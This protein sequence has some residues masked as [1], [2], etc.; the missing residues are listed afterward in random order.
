MKYQVTH[1]SR[2]QYAANVSHCYNLAHVLPRSTAQQRCLNSQVHVQPEPAMMAIRKDYFGNEVCYFS[3][4]FEHLELEVKAVSQVEVQTIDNLNFATGV[5]CQTVLSQLNAKE[6]LDAVQAVEY[7]VD[8]PLVRSAE[9]L[10]AYAEPSFA[11]NPPFL[12]A[13]MDLTQR[14]FKD[15]RYDPEST[16]VATPI[17]EVMEHRHGVCQDFA[18]VAIGCLRSLGYAARYVSGYI[19]TLPPPGQQKLVGADAS[20]AWFS[21]YVPGQGWYDF[22]PTNNKPGSDQ[23][24]IAAWGRDFSDVSPLKGVVFGGGDKQLL[25]ISVDVSRMD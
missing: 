24:I 20:H 2:Y 18:H 12:A 4:Q 9:N 11:D 7:R 10:K 19:E 6:T 16:T 17:D 1:I 25:E 5:D 21:V 13:V 14:I 3:V 22:D 23:H 15:F 8:S